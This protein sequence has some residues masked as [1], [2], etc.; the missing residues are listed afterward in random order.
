[1]CLQTDW[2]GGQVTNITKVVQKYND[3]T[4]IV[5]FDGVFGKEVV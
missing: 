2:S 5:G 1:M 3:K 4:F